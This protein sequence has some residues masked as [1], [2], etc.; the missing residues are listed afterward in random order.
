[1]SKPA[2]TTPPSS[3]AEHKAVE[4]AL[5]ADPP[6]VLIYRD[7]DEMR[8]LDSGEIIAIADAP[9]AAAELVAQ[10]QWVLIAYEPSVIIPGGCPL[11]QPGRRA[12]TGSI[13]RWWLQ[14]T[15]KT[16]GS[17]STRL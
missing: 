15:G 6:V 10:K 3:L 8:R 12:R 14:A 17:C 1:M 9:A 4:K 16:A 11:P 13:Q 2:T 5:A 7:G